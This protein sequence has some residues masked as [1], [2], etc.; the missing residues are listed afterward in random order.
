[1]LLVRF[2]EVPVP[3]Y[4]LLLKMHLWN[5]MQM[6][7]F[8]QVPQKITDWQPVFMIVIENTLFD[9]EVHQFFRLNLCFGRFVEIL[10]NGSSNLLTLI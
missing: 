8:V 1:M 4:V 10:I 7:V 3:V 5:Q 6:V 2:N 9:E